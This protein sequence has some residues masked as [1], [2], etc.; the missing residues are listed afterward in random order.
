[1]FVLAAVN[2]AGLEDLD[3]W[4]EVAGVGMVP[5]ALSRGVE[6]LFIAFLGGISSPSVVVRSEGL[7]WERILAECQCLS[8]GGEG[9]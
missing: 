5:P 2:L 4:L 9:E 8:I 6:P 7:E 1:L 3:G